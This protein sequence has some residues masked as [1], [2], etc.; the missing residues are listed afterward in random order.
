[1]ETETSE[2]TKS[3]YRIGATLFS[4][5]WPKD[6]TEEELARSDQELKDALSEANRRTKTSWDSLNEAIASFDRTCS[7]IM[8]GLKE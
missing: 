2:D 8:D 3:V 1:M 7:D 5:V 6:L 4:P